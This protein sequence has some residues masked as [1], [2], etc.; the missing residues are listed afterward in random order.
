MNNLELKL[1][2]FM[3]KLGYNYIITKLIIW[4]KREE[5]KAS[6]GLL[7]NVVSRVTRKHKAEVHH[8]Y[9][10]NKTSQEKQYFSLIFSYKSLKKTSLY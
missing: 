2:K 8:W 7:I 5:Q 1:E 4:I 10:W 6:Q 3:L 9:K